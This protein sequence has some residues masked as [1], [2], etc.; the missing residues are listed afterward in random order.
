MGQA[1]KLIGLLRVSTEKQ[2]ADRQRDAVEA[3]AKNTEAAELR[4][5]EL[6]GVHGWSVADSPEWHDVVM[7]LLRQGWHLALDSMERLL[8]ADNFDFRVYQD[9]RSA[10][11]LIYTPVG[12]QDLKEPQGALLA[13]ILG[14]IGGFERTEILRKMGNGRIAAR[15]R[16]AAAT[17]AHAMPTGLTYSKDDGWAIEPVGAARVRRAYES[18]ASGAS[19]TTTARAVGVH[20]PAITKWVRN[21]IYRGSLRSTWGDTDL[22][23]EIR[24][25]DDPIVPEPLW[26]AANARLDTSSSQARKRRERGAPDIWASAYLFSALEPLSFDFSKDEPKHVLYGRSSKRQSTTYMCRCQYPTLTGYALPDSC[27]H[28]TLRADRV[29][30]ALDRYLTDMTRDAEVVKA[31]RS[32]V[33]RNTRDVKADKKRIMKALKQSDRK[34]DILV[35]LRTDENISPSIYNKRRGIIEHERATLMKEL[36]T[37]D[38]ESHGPSPDDIEAMVSAWQWDEGW[39]HTQ[40][41]KWLAQY[42]PGGI[43]VSPDGIEGLTLRVPTAGGGSDV[44]M[45]GDE[46]IEIGGTVDVAFH[47]GIARSWTDLIGISALTSVRDPKPSKIPDGTLTTKE[48]AKLLEVPP[49]TFAH[50]V[51]HGVI[52]R[53][54]SQVGRY[55]AWNTDDISK[56]RE[57][58][59]SSKAA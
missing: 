19:L 23:G 9:V 55:Y 57:A 50:H 33:K 7:P 4:V 26:R 1:L 34:E 49:T 48:V 42:V 58:I 32:S 5:I 3:V 35:G 44:V 45:I 37:L 22:G 20:P 40:K 25:M 30:A 6:K 43:W 21:P 41:R 39:T 56:A 17:G 18:I 38:A 24:V 36:D 47:P 51:A 15:K 27:G 54:A 14:A 31:I 46:K 2:D 12:I 52:P 11:G 28:P 59:S 16:G 29:N 10:G 13:T 8:R 53:P